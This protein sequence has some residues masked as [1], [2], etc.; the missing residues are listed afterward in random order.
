MKQ[1]SNFVKGNIYRLT[2]IHVGDFSATFEGVEYEHD[3]D[4]MLCL[5]IACMDG[6]KVYLDNDFINIELSQP[7]WKVIPVS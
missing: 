3:G 7:S 6:E 1:Q 5:F 4:V 2:H